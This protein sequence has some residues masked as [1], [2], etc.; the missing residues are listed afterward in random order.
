MAEPEKIKL[1][2]IRNTF[3]MYSDLSDD[4]LL[5]AL[6]KKYYPDIPPGKFY[7][8]IDYDT[9][10]IDPT[11]GMSKTDKVL[12]NYRAQVVALLADGHLLVEDA[13]GVGKTSLATASALWLADAGRKTG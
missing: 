10:K 13:P 4:Q 6:R 12:A 3:P 1:S 9:Q 11:E 8:R 7:S 5:M 2:S